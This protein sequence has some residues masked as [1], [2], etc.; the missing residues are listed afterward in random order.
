MT[1]LTGMDVF[2]KFSKAPPGCRA[3]LIVY[4]ALCRL[5]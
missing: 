2:V 1:N 3:A 4:S 5:P